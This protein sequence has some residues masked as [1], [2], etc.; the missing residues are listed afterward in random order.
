VRSLAVVLIA[1]CAAVSG[2]E[3][4]FADALIGPNRTGERARGCCALRGG[5]EISGNGITVRQLV[6]AAYRRHAFDRREVIGGPW[7]DEGRY[8]F[9]AQVAGGHVYD[10]S[11]FPA[12]TWAT[13]R[14][15]LKN[16][17]HVRAELRERPVY[18]LTLRERGAPAPRL[19]QSDRDC[20]AEM[21]AMERGEKVP[22]PP[23]GASP[24]PGRLMARGIGMAD[25]A[26]LVT[27]WVDRPVI[28][29]TGLTGQFDVD[30]EGV[31]VRPA[32]PFGPS[33]RPSE[34]K[35][36]IFD[37]MPEQLGLHLEPMTTPIEVLV[38]ERAS[39][40]QPGEASKPLAPVDAIEGVLDAFRTH[41]VVAI[42][43]PHGNQQQHDV[44][45]TLVQQPRFFQIVDD[46]VIEGANA[47]YQD[48]VDRFI[49]G[50][51]VTVEQ[52]RPLWQESTQV[53]LVLDTPMY[54]ELL[55]AVRAV[56][57]KL[58]QPKLR[59][60]L[61]DP[62]IDWAAVKTPADHRRWI[63]QREIFPADLVRREV[64]AKNRRALLVFGQMHFQRKNAAANFTAD[65]QAATIVSLLEQAGATRVFVVWTLSSARR[66]A[67]VA[68][69]R[70]PT[71]AIIRGTALG[72][73]PVDYD[74]PR[75]AIRD[76]KP[77]FARP[78]PRAEWRS[79][80]AEDQ[81]DAVLYLGPQT[82]RLQ[83]SKALCA[84]AAYLQ[85]RRERLA[86]V[87]AGPMI[88]KD[89]EEACAP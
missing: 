19:Q 36:S 28:D 87:Q 41:A 70:Y 51:D 57:A 81:Y 15:Y 9:T 66:P 43:D 83:L 12:E 62:P 89:V 88:Q 3:L 49:A 10:R 77:D 7:L 27:P 74:G 63:E 11:G 42:S 37:T 23:C 30:V 46:I 69:W 16:K 20:G 4:R 82:T 80:R 18:A 38:V 50:G 59:V 64:L 8:D 61:G 26:A 6:E 53:Q 45:M 44:L 84:D 31:E 24:Y 54:T 22:G 1:G 40:V 17:V 52:L 76:G 39:G 73:A 85:R 75:Y 35:R 72:A 32:G 13:L 56:N 67:E 86:L 79:M 65:G 71:L 48:L 29:R 2:Q 55:P 21:R 60:L 5:G 47:R 78:L 34:T 33:Y 25:L 58:P 68:G 14:E